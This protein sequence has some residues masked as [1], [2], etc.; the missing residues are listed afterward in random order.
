M[1]AKALCRISGAKLD[2]ETLKTIVLFCAL[3]LTVSL[4]YLLYGVDLA[5]GF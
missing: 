3:G 2:A 5:P 1:I 4:V